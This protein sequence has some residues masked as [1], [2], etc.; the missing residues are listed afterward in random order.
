MNPK[1]KEY[2]GVAVVIVLLLALGAVWKYVAAY[3]SSVVPSATFPVTGEGKVTAIPDVAQ[4]SFG[5]TTEGGKDI[6]ALQK[7]NTE[8]A[9]TAIAAVKAL[10]VE[11][12]DIKTS[13]YR[14]SPRY[15]YYQ[16]PPV[17]FY[18]TGAGAE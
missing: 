1:I 17:T 4:F 13:Y 16:C 15:Q 8:K 3:S 6:A 2:V 12:K 9:N 5:I 7:E 11:D 14:I 10:G 18:S